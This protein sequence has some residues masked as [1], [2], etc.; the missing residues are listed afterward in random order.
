MKHVQFD[1]SHQS[2]QFDRAEVEL[3]LGAI[4]KGYALDR[5]A[6]ELKDRKISDFLL[7]GGHSSIIACGDHNGLGGW[8]IGIGNPLF[9]SKRLGT[10]VLS[11][12]AM[13]TS[14]SNIQYFRHQG[15]K[16]GHILDPRTGWP[17]ES[18]LSVT[19]LAPTAAEADALST[20]FYVMG[21]EKVLECCDNL[22]GV[23]VVLIPTPSGRELRPIIHGIPDEKLFLDKE[24]LGS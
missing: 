14:G 23:G 21:V 12:V 24:Q 8:P 3:N 1:E 16:Y 9:T 2:I 4:G 20:A 19:V 13:A 7:H 15:K 11:D 6:A 17:V 5:A 10:I 22:E 18:M